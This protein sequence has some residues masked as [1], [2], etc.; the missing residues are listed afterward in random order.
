M[1]YC[2]ISEKMMKLLLYAPELDL[3]LIYMGKVFN[4]TSKF[5]INDVLFLPI[6]RD[7]VGEKV[8]HG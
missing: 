5:I 2:H 4:F 6:Y 3:G 7:A 8:T 1:K